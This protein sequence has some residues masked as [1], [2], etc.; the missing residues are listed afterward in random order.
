VARRKGFDSIYLYTHELM[1][2]NLALYSRIGYVEYD[3]RPFGEAS[4]VYLR[5]RLT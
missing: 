3:R 2:E 5:K 1:S 4:R